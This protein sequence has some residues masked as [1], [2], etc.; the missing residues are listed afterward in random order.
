M[1]TPP[2][3][4]PHPASADELAA[5]TLAQ[6]Q[7]VLAA[8]AHDAAAWMAAAAKL[9]HADAQAVLGQWCL[10]GHGTGRDASEA[11]HWFLCAA[12]RG[13]A[14][15]MNMAG[16]CHEQGWGTPADAAK[17][18]HWYRLAAAQAL[19]EA[20][21]NLANLLVAGTGVARDHAQAFELYRLAA[22]QGYVKAYAKLGR[23]FEDGLVVARDEAQAFEW[24][25]RGAEGGDFRGQFCYAG[26]LAARGREAEALHWLAQVPET[27]TPRYLR[28]AGARLLESAR[29]AI[30]A[31][32]ERMRERGLA[33][34]GG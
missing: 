28:D 34:A 3:L 21:Y 14:M 31:L 29:P 19:P 9:G 17:A 32:G 13:H 26:L 5:I 7:A 20:R 15:G 25:R 22:E 18:A 11:L 27:A 8:E 4:E 30:R 2:A 33:T 1:T 24:Y 16:R 12:Q 10:D 6:W 23:F